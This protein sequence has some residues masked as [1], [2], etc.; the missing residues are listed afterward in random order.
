MSPRDAAA[1]LVRRE[2]NA[3]RA[4]E[5]RRI[6]ALEELRREASAFLRPGERVWVIG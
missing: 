6:A 3:Q 1:A 2:A 5:A 4:R